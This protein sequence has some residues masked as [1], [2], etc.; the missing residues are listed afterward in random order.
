MFKTLKARI[1]I[2]ILG[3]SVLGV[4]SVSYYLT[5]TLN[6]LSD[7]TSQ[8][9]LEMLSESIFQ[10]LRQSMFTGDPAMVN[11]ALKQ[12]QAIKG[13]DGLE[14]Q[15][16]PA[17]I[18]QFQL[19]ASPS[20]DKLIQQVF[21]STDQMV[22]EKYEP[23][24]YIR[25]LK[26][27]TAS[28]ECLS[29]HSNVKEG[30]ALG[31]MDLTISLTDNDDVIDAAKYSLILALIVSIVILVVVITLFMTKEILNPLTELRNRIASLVSGDKDLTK[32]L[33]TS[34]GN[35]FAHTALA[36]NNFVSM[37][38]DTVNEVKTLGDQNQTIALDITQAS[39]R[40]NESVIKE[41]EIVSQATSKSA[42][43][44]E[45]LNTTLKVSE[46]TQQNILEASQDLDT[47]RGSMQQL[48]GEVEDYIQIENELSGDLL[49]LKEDADQVKSV[50]QVIK[51]IADQT[52]LL[53]LN[54]AIEAARAGE[55]GRGFAVVADE[56][57]KLAERTQKSLDE[58][59]ISVST[60]IQSIN[61]VSDNMV[62]NAQ[63]L[64]KLSDISNDV[65]DK[66]AITSSAMS[67]ST[68]VAKDS[69]ADTQD[70]VE[71]IDWMIK[72]V[73]QI[74]EHSSTNQESIEHIKDELSKLLH[75]AQ[76]LKQHIDEFIS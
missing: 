61:N 52:N 55:H 68:T 24:H 69:L 41:R 70:A 51:E 7:K 1:I 15:K 58:I 25:L 20:S 54:A 44:T 42:S 14:V 22:I 75:V 21:R 6:S 49:H 38:Q 2:S 34:K 45:I 36:V 13:I 33:D 57:R 53:A 39:E 40:I 19:N 43:I 73:S 50:L 46:M 74:N 28:P 71:Q 4:I 76:S 8:H 16:S 66:I 12:A 3:I 9:S 30:D 37:V 64:T 35:E 63:N 72:K 27:L 26:P 31:V 23:K 65:N 29:C 32:R 60:I 48:F 56:V 5:H 10:T 59:E 62:K 67:E 17:V 11:D 18:E 47:A